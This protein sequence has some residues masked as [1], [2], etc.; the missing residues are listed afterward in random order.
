MYPHKIKPKLIIV[1]LFF[2]T[3]DR[4][5]FSV[6]LNSLISRADFADSFDALQMHA[7]KRFMI[8]FIDTI[9]RIKHYTHYW[10]ERKSIQQ[11]VSTVNSFAYGII[12][13][14]RKKDLLHHDEDSDSD[15]LHRFMTCKNVDGNLLSDTDL[16]DTILNFIIAGRD[17]TALALSWTFYNLL[18]YPEIEER[19][20]QEVQQ[21]VTDDVESDPVRL[22]EVVQKMTYTHAV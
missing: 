19:V 16:R 11:H 20:L 4:L 22:Y 9:E 10:T 21:Y 17:T 7:F 6:Q 13:E 14:R 2:F 12:Q 1:Q 8:P 3:Y 18:M 5:G 15:L